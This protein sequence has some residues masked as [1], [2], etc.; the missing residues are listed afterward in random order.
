M[1]LFLF[2]TKSFVPSKPS[3]NP[4]RVILHWS[5][6]KQ[7]SVKR[8]HYSIMKVKSSWSDK[9]SEKREREIENQPHDKASCGERRERIHLK[10]TASEV[11]RGQVMAQM[12]WPRRE[13]RGGSL[14]MMRERREIRE[15]ERSWDC[16]ITLA[17]VW[18]HFH[19]GRVERETHRHI[20][21]FQLSAPSFRSV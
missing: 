15:K 5:K 14:W 1:P 19:D 11:K 4:Q 6:N 7:L 17:V 2:I 8:S 10:A 9:S 20:F 21:Y 3:W 13:A 16:C 12:G 18:D